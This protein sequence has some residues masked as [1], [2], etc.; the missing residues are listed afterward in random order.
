[1]IPEAD[2]FFLLAGGLALAAGAFGVRRLR[3]RSE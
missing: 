2:T 3:D 1:V